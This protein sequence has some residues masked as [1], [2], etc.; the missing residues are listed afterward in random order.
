M[1]D[2]QRL[3]QQTEAL[4]QFVKTSDERYKRIKESGL[5]GDFYTEVKPFADEVKQVNDEWKDAAIFWIA[6][7]MP[8]NIHQQQI[9]S[10]H[11]HIEVISIQ[12]FF[13]ETSRTRFKNLVSSS[14]YV[15]QTIVLS[16]D[17]DNNQ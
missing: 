9:D 14:I 5:K 3:L 10:C 11:E 13:P 17:H 15:L 2:K 6:A 7:E 12:S 16:L 1:I 8:K 4:I